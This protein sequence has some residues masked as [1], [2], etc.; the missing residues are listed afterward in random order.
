MGKEGYLQKSRA[1]KGFHYS[2][3]K[4]EMLDY[5]HRRTLEM[6]KDILSVFEKN[7]IRYAICG[8]TLLGAATTGKFIPWD[9]DFDVCVFEEDYDKMVQLL[10]A[11]SQIGG[12][13]N[14]CLQCPQTDENYYLDWC[15]VRDKNSHVYPDIPTAK[16]NGVWIDLYKLVHVKKK[17]ANWIIAR[18]HLDYVNRRY[19][20]GGLT[21]EQ[22]KDRLK[23]GHLKRNYIKERFKSLFNWSN[24]DAYIIWSASKVIVRKDWVLPLKKYDF[25]GLVLTSFGKAEEYL[26][27]HY[28]L[29]YNVLPDYELRRV[30]LNEIQFKEPIT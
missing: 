29:T 26:K 15:K 13:K 16:E 3:L 11:E 14:W 6:M 25:E 7:N 9:D 24:K 10:I 20:L 21:R 28:G 22:L 27:Q 2:V 4:P 5:L 17:D 23:K 18:G 30:G 12:G 8:G 19:A 1:Y